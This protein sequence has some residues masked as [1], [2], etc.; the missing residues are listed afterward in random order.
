MVRAGMAGGAVVT[1]ADGGRDAER[2]SAF[3]DGEL[4]A[5]SP[6]GLIRACEAGGDLAADW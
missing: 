4:G 6:E 3:M 1:E 2:L 5:E